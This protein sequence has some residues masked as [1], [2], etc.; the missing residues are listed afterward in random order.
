MRILYLTNYVAGNVGGIETYCRELIQGME[1]RGHAVY[2]L[3]IHPA[4]V[5]ARVRPTDYVPRPYSWSRYYF[6]R[7]FYL[8]DYRFHN[9]LRRSFRQ[10]VKSF[11]PD[12]VHCLHLHLGTTLVGYSGPSIVTAHG[13]EVTACPP[14][15]Q[16]VRAATSVHCISQYTAERTAAID[17]CLM[18]KVH[19]ASWGIREPLSDCH[20]PK[21]YDLVTVGRVVRR[22]NLDTVVNALEQLPH[23]RYAV[24]G[25]GPELG[26][27]KALVEKKRM[28]NVSFLGRVTEEEKWRLLLSSRAFVLCPRH[29]TS[30]DVEGLGLVYFEAHRC[31][32]PVIACR[33][34]GVSDAIGKAG[35]QI[36]HACD[37]VQ[38]RAA[39]EAL[40]D[41]GYYSRLVEQVRLRQASKPWHGF[42]AS[43]ESLYA[44]AIG[45]AP[46]VSEP[47][48]VA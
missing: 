20:V 18:H 28:T 36:E 34:G 16:G 38:M 39:I 10:A 45:S 19:V 3:Q 5:L 27:L 25:D 48:R 33:S 6:W 2:S 22:K 44:G 46:A 11:R 35:I 26:N 15:L 4:E 40:Q 30:D 42:L 13:L 47:A 8:Q 17:P 9:S 24:A 23:I 37:V 1:Q 7:G 14:I 31:A 41:P 32:L 21:Q 12:V 29:E 43:V